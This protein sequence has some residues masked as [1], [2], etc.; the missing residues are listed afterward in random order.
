MMEKKDWMR[1]VEHEYWSISAANPDWD[2][3]LC[4]YFLEAGATEDDV[5][6]YSPRLAYDSG[7]TEPD[8]V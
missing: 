5:W 1:A 3:D 6:E 8:W 2:K 4:A 7:L